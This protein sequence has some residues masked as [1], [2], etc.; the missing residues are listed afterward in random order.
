M[1]ETHTTLNTLAQ[2]RVAHN[3][4]PTDYL[5]VHVVKSACISL[6]LYGFGSRTHGIG[7]LGIVPLIGDP[8]HG[9]CVLISKCFVCKQNRLE[10]GKLGNTNQRNTVRALTQQLEQL[11]QLG[12]HMFS[13]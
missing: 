5:H 11:E 9:L 6:T 1:S 3:K 4:F 8:F 2:Q 10:C 12:E 7:S 13:V